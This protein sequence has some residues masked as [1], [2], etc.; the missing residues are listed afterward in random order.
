MLLT[1]LKVLDYDKFDVTLCLISKSGAL[2]EDLPS[3]VRQIFVYPDPNSLLARL[4]YVLYSKGRIDFLE[5]LAMRCKCRMRYDT[6]VSFCEGRAVK[7]HGY[8]TDRAKRNISWVHSDLYE[9]GHY[10]LGPGLSEDCERTCYE[11]MDT[12]VFVSEEARRNF[13]K[14]GYRLKDSRV[15]HNPLDVDGIKAY[16]CGRIPKSDVF[17]IVLCGG[18]RRVKSFDRIVRVSKILKEE[19]R[20]FV[21]NIVGDGDEYENLK[22][23]IKDLRLFDCVHLLGFHYPPYPMMAEADLFVSCSVSEGYPMNVCEALCLGLPVIATRCSGNVEILG[24]NNEYGLIA[25][26]DDQSI[27][28]CIKM[29]MDDSE[30]RSHYH[31]QALRAS[32]KFDLSA[33]MQEIYSVL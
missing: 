28:E 21:V 19:N 7:F 3:P 33:T 26:Q 11:R 30:L 9:H 5:R 12:V 31:Q 20:R 4:G 32:E 25:E 1:I 23:Q 27:C 24:N 18:L 10:T 15:I 14:L 16:K 22:H 17:T 8:V 2:L 29:M 13:S 6:I